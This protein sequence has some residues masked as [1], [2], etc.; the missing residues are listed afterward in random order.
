MKYNN[1]VCIDLE[2]CCWEDKPS[3]EI[4][5]VGLVE[6]D[7]E[8]N[9]IT[10]EAQYYVKPEKDE[11]SEFCTKLTGITPKMIKNQGRPLKEV[12]QSMIKKFGGKNKIY[13]AWGRDD[14]TLFRECQL[15]GIEE[16]F[17][18]FINL[19]VLY[20]TL[21]RTGS[22]KIGQVEAMKQ[23][24]LEFEGNQHSGLVDAKNL[25]RLAIEMFKR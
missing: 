2:M 16:P 7:L 13:M 23:Y 10:K 3:G 22:S 1:I 19:A 20:R 25:A 12:I 4:I 21:H 15:K 8:K 14:L 18:E 24:G 9:Q 6:I 17:L 11:I 5:E